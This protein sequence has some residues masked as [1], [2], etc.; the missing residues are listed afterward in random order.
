MVQK[1]KRFYDA[2]D[3]LVF[4][5]TTLALALWGLW[6][7]FRRTAADSQGGALNRTL[8]LRHDPQ[9]CSDARSCSHDNAR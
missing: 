9:D 6:K 1:I 3:Y 7:L 2:A 8:E 5:S 4:R